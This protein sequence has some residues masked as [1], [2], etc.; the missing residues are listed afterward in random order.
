MKFAKDTLL[1]QQQW[2]NV[3]IHVSNLD[4]YQLEKYEFAQK[5][6]KQS[7]LILWDVVFVEKK[8][9]GEHI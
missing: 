7:I 6:S 9:V 4:K 3:C 2:P 1:M 8:N 5:L